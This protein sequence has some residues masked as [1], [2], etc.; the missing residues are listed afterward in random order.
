[1]SILNKV[2]IGLL[3]GGMLSVVLGI[4]FI[5]LTIQTAMKAKA[6]K[7]RRSKNKKKNKKIKRDI[8]QL[9]K[10]KA[11][12][13]LNSILLLILGSV[14]IASAFYT[15]FYQQTTL[16]ENDG[17]IIVQS[18]F[19]VDS[20]EKDIKGIQNG[21]NPEKTQEKL[22]TMTTMMASYGNSTPSGM[23]TLDRQRIL[24]KYYSGILELGMN[25]NRQTAKN[26]GEPEIIEEYLAD[27]V[28][29]KDGQQKIFKLFK[30][31]EAALK[32]KR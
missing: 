23:L 6:L 15:R 22:R 10:K 30:V 16:N 31:N 26:M 21:A 28:K 19:L 8:R 14:L 24:R 5:F 18:Y 12:S 2:F 20:I 7:K 29:L 3:S 9:K 17:E 13:R 32:Q 25:L 27:I 11:K 1:M 4:I